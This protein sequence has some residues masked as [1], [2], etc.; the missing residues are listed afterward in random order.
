MRSRVMERLSEL[1]LAARA[2]AFTIGIRTAQ[3]IEV[4]RL[5]RRVRAVSER[6]SPLWST[7]AAATGTLGAR[8]ELEHVVP[9]VVLV[10]RI[11]TGEDVAAV[12][13]QAVVCRVTYEEHKRHLAVAFRRVHQDLYARM[14]T[15]PIEQLSA[16]G[17]ER[18]HAAGLAC[19]EVART[20]TP[21]GARCADPSSAR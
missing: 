9:V 6:W 10:E 2:S 14:R 13:D 7:A 11:L 12:L 16:L 20:Q 3:P 1:T 15:C 17:W 4:Q 21:R 18:Y 19:F 8:V 5:Q